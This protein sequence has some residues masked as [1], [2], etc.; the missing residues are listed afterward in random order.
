MTAGQ[1]AVSANIKETAFPH[2]YCLL[3]Y[4]ALLLGAYPCKATH[5]VTHNAD[6]RTV[7]SHYK[8]WTYK[9]GLAVRTSSRIGETF[10][11][12]RVLICVVSVANEGCKRRRG[13]LS[14]GAINLSV[15]VEWVPRVFLFVCTIHRDVA[16][17][18]NTGAWLF[19]WHYR[20]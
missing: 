17:V 13:Q 8:L 1:H 3:L 18:G 15:A 20:S 6:P 16:T 2:P 5:K 9:L 11:Q 10:T 19:T 12:R 4:P 14:F 7:Q